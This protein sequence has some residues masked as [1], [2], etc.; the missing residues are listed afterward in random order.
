MDS[1]KIK[2]IKKINK[3]F[4]VAQ[5]KRDIMSVTKELFKVNNNPHRDFV[6]NLN[7]NK[8]LIV[9]KNGVYN[10]KTYVFR[11]GIPSDNMSMSVNYNYRSKHSKKYGELLRFL[12]DIQ[13]NK[14]ERDFL[15]TYLSH[16]LC[17]NILEWFT[18]LTGAGRNGKSK[19]IELIKKT[20]GNYYGS[21]KSQL[22]TRPQ[23]DASSP[24]PSLLN[25][26]HKKIVI[27][28]EPEKKAK[29]NSGFIKFIT[30]RDST[31]LREC[32]KN[33]MCDFEPKFI[34]LF[35]CNDIPETDEIDT[36]FSK[37]LRCINFP[38]EFCVNPTNDNQRL[39][40]TNIN[41]KFDDWRADFMLLLIDHFKKYMETKKIQVTENIL[42]WTNQ[43]KEE[44]DVYLNFLTEC[45][46]ESITHIRTS[47]LYEAFK[48]WF[49]ANNPKTH[50]PSNREF[51]IN[52]KKHIT[53]EKVKVAG[54]VVNGVKKI[55]LLAEYA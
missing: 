55:K 51:T 32:H 45:T 25:L 31:Q 1:E 18:I 54:L 6:Q 38:T 26:R 36:A 34:T 22:F 44:T 13:P 39:I 29:L 47:A 2:E 17:E 16:A 5:T 33:E 42:K 52:L 14:E 24:D 43:Y 8:Y 49:V 4:G 19:L 12:E 30:G 27:A 7:S 15:L 9:F 40:D 11:D 35:V 48:T 10:L 20:F 28:S 41:E 21:V 23:P 37:R 53:V 50:I 3:M 46:E